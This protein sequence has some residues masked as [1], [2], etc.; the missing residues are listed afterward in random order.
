MSADHMRMG[1][2]ASGY[3]VAMCLHC[4]EFYVPALPVALNV[5]SATVKAFAANHR[6]CRKP[7]D[8]DLALR[9][10]E[11]MAAADVRGM[12]QLE[13]AISARSKVHP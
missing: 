12:T 11:I 13:R 3:Y 10:R 1:N 7:A 5:F 8:L 4:G 2:T 6:R 9:E